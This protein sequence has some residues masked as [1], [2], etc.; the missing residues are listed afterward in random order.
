MTN[1]AE[2]GSRGLRA[3]FAL[4]SLCAGITAIACAHTEIDPIIPFAPDVAKQC[5]K[6]ANLA[7][8]RS[9]PARD[10]GFV[11][12]VTARD[13]RASRE[14]LFHRLDTGGGSGLYERLMS[15]KNQPLR[16]EPSC[17]YLRLALQSPAGS[18]E[19]EQRP[20][21]ELFARALTRAGFEVVPVETEHYWWASS[22]TLDAGSNAAAWTILVRAVPEIGDG[23]IQFT[24]IQKTVDGR[25]D[26]FSGMQS[27]HLF[28]KKE[29]TETAW[30]AASGIARELLPAANRRCDDIDAALEE[31]ELRLEQ[32]RNELTEEIE[33]VR[34]E[35]A[36]RREEAS[37]GKQLVIE[38][39]G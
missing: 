10:E 14:D 15:G 30:N 7:F 2:T 29:A 11:N 37:R 21:R 22:L 9:S 33:R 24:T 39:E 13:P 6:W 1:Y 12:C 18:D 8:K 16:I 19:T 28:G 34:K 35:K 36:Q 32:L 4:I 5:D 20:M 38:V 31:A 17:A 27:L 23:A 25:E 3:R 26:L